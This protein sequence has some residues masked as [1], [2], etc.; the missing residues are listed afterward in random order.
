MSECY[1]FLPGCFL[2]V[3]ISSGYFT[4]I[5]AGSLPTDA[6]GSVLADNVT[7]VIGVL[8][9]YFQLT[10]SEHQSIA[11]YLNSQGIEL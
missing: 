10:Y 2:T 5:L 6:P 11:D 4:V 3:S 9:S 7:Q 1:E 8:D